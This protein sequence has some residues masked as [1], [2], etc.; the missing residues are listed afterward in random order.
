ML[1]IVSP[2]TGTTLR[3]HCEVRRDL[4]KLGRVRTRYDAGNF[5]L[6][7]QHHPDA[8]ALDPLPNGLKLHTV[9]VRTAY[10]LSRSM[11][12]RSPP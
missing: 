4:P 3:K 5:S 9:L 2:T 10:T 11:K 12:Q 8:G 7:L 1:R 6:E